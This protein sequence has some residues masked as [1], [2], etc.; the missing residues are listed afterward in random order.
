MAVGVRWSSAWPTLLGLVALAIGAILGSLGRLLPV[1]AGLLLGFGLLA[2]G[3]IVTPVI[4]VVSTADEVF[5]LQGRQRTYDPVS[6]LERHDRLRGCLTGKSQPEVSGSARSGDDTCR[7]PDASLERDPHRPQYGRDE[8]VLCVEAVQLWEP[9]RVDLIIVATSGRFLK[10]AVAWQER[11]EME[12]TIPRVELWPDSHLAML[13]AAAFTS[14]PTSG[15]RAL[16]HN[17]RA[18]APEPF[19]TLGLS[20]RMRCDCSS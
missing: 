15:D 6:I 7:D 17:V 11:R 12:R 16:P 14:S 8:L 4:L 10:D 5:V 20:G 2:I 1:V 13:L 9:P 3:W 18:T 19:L